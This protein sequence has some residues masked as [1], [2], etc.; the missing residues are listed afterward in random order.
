MSVTWMISKNNATP[1][2]L[3]ALG[4][5]ACTVTFA[6]NGEDVMHVTVDDDWTA[7]PAF[8]DKTKLDLIRRTSLTEF[9]CVFTGWVQGIP[10]HASSESESLSYTVEGPASRLRKIDYAQEWTIITEDDGTPG[11]VLE[12]RVILGETNAGARISTGTQI[13]NIL[14]YANIARRLPIEVGTI[15]N[16]LTAPRDEQENISC[17][18]GI[19]SMLRWTPTHVLSWNYNN[20]VNGVYTPQANVT[21]AADM[22]AVNAALHNGDVSTA[23]FTPRYDLQVP[24]VSVAFRIAGTK[25]GK[26][27]E[28]R[29]YDTAGNTADPESMSYYIDLQ[30]ADY[31]TM[32]QDVVTGDYPIGFTVAAAKDWLKTLVPWL[33]D[34]PAADWKLTGLTRSGTKNLPRFLVSGS[35]CKWMGL[36]AEPETITATAEIKTRDKD[37]NITEDTTREIPIKLISTNAVTKSYSKRLQTGSAEAVP[38]GIAAAIFA[39]WSLLQWEGSFVIDEEDPTFSIIPGRVVNWTGA[40]PEWASMRAVVQSTSIDIMSGET[41]IST[42]PCARLEADSRVA[43]F[44]AVRSRRNPTASNRDTGEVE[45]LSGAE[46]TAA[47]DFFAA[48]AKERRQ[49]TIRKRGIDGKLQIIDIDPAYIRYKNA[50]DAKAQKL[51]PREI[52]ITDAAGKPKTI[53]VISSEPYGD[54]TGEPAPD[55]PTKPPPCGH[56]GNAPGAGGATDHPGDDVGGSTGATGGGNAGDHPGDSPSPPSSGDCD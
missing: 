38:T 41:H 27:T 25:D 24:G 53:Q 19:L 20:R 47:Q 48:Q 7:N 16:G 43:M 54:G 31:Q 9:E 13:R 33:N 2:S 52:N 18:Q 49:I 36:L 28:R 11:R 5:T 34:L 40:R 45:G 3:E 46:N 44:R 26:P 17:L 10:R 35:I 15:D 1:Q 39:E 6:A 42:G 12:P 55:D 14:A 21:P 56:P 51:Q 29:A 37:G 23:D 8:P 32:R 22:P 30:G 50:Q 4:I